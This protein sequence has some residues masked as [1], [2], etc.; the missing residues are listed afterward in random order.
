MW[1]ITLT[2]STVTSPWKAQAWYKPDAEKRKGRK[3]QL[4]SSTSTESVKEEK[5]TQKDPYSLC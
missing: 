1:F 3:E 5:H 2:P 4:Q